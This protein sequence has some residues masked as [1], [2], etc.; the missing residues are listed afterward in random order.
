MTSVTDLAAE[1]ARRTAR[2]SGPPISGAF[3]MQRIDDLSNDGLEVL[4]SVLRKAKAARMRDLR[5]RAKASV[6]QLT[7]AK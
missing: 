2:R 4:L 5:R 6:V 3:L 1:R 7:P